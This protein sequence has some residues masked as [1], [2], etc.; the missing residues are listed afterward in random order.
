MT[1]LFKNLYFK[2]E[3]EL[4]QHFQSIFEENKAN[5][6]IQDVTT[7]EYFLTSLVGTEVAL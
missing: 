2:S 6:D 5:I 1:S 4:V 3:K 7:I